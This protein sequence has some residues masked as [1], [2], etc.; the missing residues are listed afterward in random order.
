MIEPTEEDWVYMAGFLDGEGC[1]TVTNP[2]SCTAHIMVYN[3]YKPVIEWCYE[4]F[5]GR[6]LRPRLPRKEN[7]RTVYG[8]QIT[9]K[10][11]VIFIEKIAPYL[12][13]KMRQAAIILAIENTK[14][15][16]RLGRKV[17]PNFMDERVRLIQTLKDMKHE[18]H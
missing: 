18:S 15:Q 14:N 6:L 10:D 4:K 2:R 12:K 7:H 11:A 1:F 16:K 5:G 17:H 3:T 13:E 8:W 9:G